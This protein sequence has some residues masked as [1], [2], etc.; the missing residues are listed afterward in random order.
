MPHV[1]LVCRANVCR[2]PMALAIAAHGL[3]Q[4][5]LHLTVQLS[6]AGTHALPGRGRADPRALATLLRHGYAAP[7]P[8]RRAVLAQDFACFDQILAM[9]RENLAELQALC[10]RAQQHKLQLFLQGAA[11]AKVQDIPDPYFGATAGFERVLQLCEAGARSLIAQ[12]AA[13]AQAPP[14]YTA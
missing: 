13:P 10:P 3:Q 6:S 14:P 1:L 11:A 9:D 5:G 2:S 7:A 4:A 8:H 12:W